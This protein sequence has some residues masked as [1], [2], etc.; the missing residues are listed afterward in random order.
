MQIIYDRETDTLNIIFK[1][2]SV[3]DSEYIED[4]GV[5]LDFGKDDSILGVEILSYSKKVRE[6][7]DVDLP[8]ET[9]RA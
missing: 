4:K 6:G 9:V 5:I 2:G 8:V 7:F 1:K 3:V